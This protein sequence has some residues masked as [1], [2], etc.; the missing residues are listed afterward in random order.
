MLCGVGRELTYFCSAHRLASACSEGS[1]CKE[2][3]DRY[4]CVRPY[5]CPAT[6]HLS[7]LC[8]WLRVE[9]TATHLSPCIAPP[10]PD[11]EAQ[12]SS[13]QGQVPSPFV[14]KLSEIK[15]TQLDGGAVKVADSTVF[16]IS[17]SIA[18]AE[19]TVEPGAVR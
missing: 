1:P 16:P 5:P 14:Y 12:V 2:L 18:V 19:V 7:V 10:P 4:G 3:Q 15:A 8:V 17:T 11:S 6:L 13:P 9:A